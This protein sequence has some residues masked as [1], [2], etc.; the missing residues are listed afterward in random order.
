MRYFWILLFVFGLMNQ[1]IAQ[2]DSVCV[3]FR[4]KAYNLEEG[5]KIFISGNHSK[6]GGW[7]PD[8]ISLSRKYNGI[9]DLNVRF[10]KNFIAEY[11]FTKGSW[12]SEA[13][14]EM[15]IVFQNNVLKVTNDTTVVHVITNW[16]NEFDEIQN[17]ARQVTGNVCYHDSL[18]FEGLLPR[19]MIVWLPPGYDAED[20]KRYPVLYM[21]DGQNLFDPATSSFGVDWGMDEVADSL[22]NIGEIE[23]VIIVGI[24]NTINR[25][26]EYSN[27]S[28]TGYVYMNFLV[29]K[30]KPMIDSTYKTL[31]GR[32]NTAVAG[33]S[34]GG[35][36][37]FM[38]AWE[39]PEVFSKA[40][41]FSPAYKYKHF[42]YVTVVEKYS[43]TKKE[44]KFYI[45]NGGI[46]IEETI[47]PGIDEMISLLE[48]MGYEK[49][50]D[51]FVLFDK[52]ARH[53]ESD[54]GT[55]AHVP[56]KL[57]FGKE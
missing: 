29:N 18:T 30:I 41:C 33:S 49:G 37:S 56:L 44:I 32:E 31:P 14:N 11:K 50:K 9:W 47:Q 17:A 20:D 45:D 7:Q 4:V 8:S 25:F 46:G 48:A 26:S 54:W 10:P 19:G 15:G 6:L 40:A 35:L 36:I 2:T 1:S 3:K 23:P 28:D 16:K 39:Y 22:I 42:D 55:R 21:H 12:E 34:M 51:L 53:F 27:S 24:N 38:L 52:E 57:F 13:S 5:E 43:S